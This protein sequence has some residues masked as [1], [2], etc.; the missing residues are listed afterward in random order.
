MK[1]TR[2]LRTDIQI[3]RALAIGMVVLFHAGLP[4]FPGGF[5]GVDIFL[6]ISG[7]LITRMI[8]RSLTARTFSI[9]VFFL[10]RAKR[11]LPAALT[12]YAVTGIAALWLLTDAE[13]QRYLDTLFGAL[14]FT[15]N[16][17]LWQ[18]TDYFSAAAK[19]NVQLH[20]WSLS[21]EE[22]F[23]L[24]AP[25]AMVLAPRRF[26]MP[27]MLAGLALSIAACFFLVTRSPVATFYLLPTRA[28]ELIIGAVVALG[29]HHLT[30][31]TRAVVT[32]VGP[33]ALLILLAV[34]IA[35]PGQALGFPHP[36]VDA[37]F[38]ALCTAVLIAGRP[39]FLNKHDPISATGYWLGGL[40]YSL[41]LVHWP[42]FA[43]AENAYIGQ[44]IP[45][46]TRLVLLGVSVILAVALHRGIERPLHMMRFNGF[47]WPVAGG[48]IAATVAVW[49]L[50]VSLSDLRIGPR[51][52][53]T[54]FQPNYGLDRSCEDEKGFRDAQTCRT[55]ENP[56]TLLW[57]DSFAM[58]IAR[59]LPAHFDP[60]QQ[61]T[62]S[63]CAPAVGIA[64]IEHGSYQDRSWAERCVRFNNQVY[65][66]LLSHE[67]VKTVI[68]S[69]TFS[70][71]LG[72][73]TLAGLVDE[74]GH[75]SL[76][77]MKFELGTAHFVNTLTKLVESGKKVIVVGPTPTT[78][79]DLSACVER[80]EVGLIVG[81]VR[82][83]CR[84]SR[85]AAETYRAE[86][87]RLLD[88]L[89]SLEGV[90]VVDIFDIFCDETTC[91]PTRDGVILFRDAGHISV[92]GADFIRERGL[93]QFR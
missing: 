17:E 63:S 53:A 57:G 25:V 64:Q 41:Y 8:A 78:L 56:S 84:F 79:V 91:D 10:N 75:L 36:S 1:K 81:G 77:P 48:F 89:R 44:E 83:D 65:N 90:T 59:A 51:D 4:G 67:E 73:A 33:V 43:F 42:L 31:K 88:R 68:I 11:L 28:W 27:M 93:L 2:D 26:W 71:I 87:R 61:A 32:R 3:L 85:S 50:A 5:L 60:I 6:V 38:V 19:Q 47:R 86:A 69:S 15:A 74:Q 30:P 9:P 7:Y 92:A 18:T 54:L 49:V 34:P 35:T 52:Y 66:F 40:S 14:T 37:F 70:Q 76:R 55:G 46:P 80:R 13:M 23:Y 24:I 62:M 16:I 21:L 39:S 82:E 20:V 22:Q 58:H 12:V 45:L 72:K 29:E